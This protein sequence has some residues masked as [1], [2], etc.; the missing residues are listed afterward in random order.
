MPRRRTRAESRARYYIRDEAKRR[1]WNT[2]HVA[3]G[4]NFLEEN[5]I[6]AHF[7]DIGLNLDK[8]DF[9]ICLAGEPSIVVEAKNEAS[10]ITDAINEAIA[11]ANQINATN[12]YKIRIAVGAAGE[13]DAG[14]TV[15]VRFLSGDQW[16]ALKA[17]GQEVTTIPT[18]RE[19]ELALVADDGTTTVSIPASSEFID[20]AVELSILLRSAKVEAPLRPKVIGAL[21][22][23]IYQGEIDTTPGQALGSI[24]DLVALAINAADD[25]AEPKKITLIDALHLS[26]A[27]FDRL[28]P[29]VRRAIA[30]LRRLNVRSVLHTD[31]DFLGMFY[32]AFLRYGYDN[33]A[34][35][36]VFTPRHITRFCVRLAGANPSD[37]V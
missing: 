18:I 1:G 6:V 19:T 33:N 5:E 26:G 32:E 29:Y 2:R 34:L 21:V 36:I 27:D 7:S 25:I 30:I 9:L 4:G 16:I 37:R 3:A 24:N 20:A 22:V 23:A 10:K 31:T 8:P 17:A 11:Y 14:F 12:R 28:E 15:V 35:G 13:E